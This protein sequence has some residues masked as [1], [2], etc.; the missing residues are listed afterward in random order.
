MGIGTTDR[1][2][3]GLVL[4]KNTNNIQRMKVYVWMPAEGNP[5]G[6]VAMETDRYY[7]SFWPRGDI[8]ADGEG[9]K[10]A[11]E[12]VDADI[13]YHRDLDFHLEGRRKPE[14]INLPVNKVKDSAINDVLER[15]LRDNNVDPADVTLEAAERK[16]VDFLRTSSFDD[17]PEKQLSLTRYAYLSEY[18][19]NFN[20]F[21]NFVDGDGEPVISLRNP[22]S[23]TTFVLNAIVLSL[24][25]QKMGWIDWSSG[26]LEE[27]FRNLMDVPHRPPPARF[28]YLGFGTSSGV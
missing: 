25:P 14:V 9:L 11:G 3:A 23:C 18:P 27:L 5:Y 10:A 8:K 17:R 16:I 15:F 21:I 24:P 7:M 19:N 28:L 1:T 12:G 13:V 26:R 22:Q 6:H 2:I 20:K 4:Q